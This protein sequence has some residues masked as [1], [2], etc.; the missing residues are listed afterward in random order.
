MD[1]E[2]RFLIA[3]VCSPK[4]TGPEHLKEVA[5]NVKAMETLC[6]KHADKVERVKRAQEYCQR[7]YS[8][9]L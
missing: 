2:T 8:G 4:D 5:N 6:S 9:E 7:I 3:M 1:F